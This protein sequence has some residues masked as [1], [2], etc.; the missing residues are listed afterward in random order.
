M[1]LKRNSKSKEINPSCV[2]TEAIA[3]DS[4]Q[5]NAVT[6]MYP[7][8]GFVTRIEHSLLYTMI[9]ESAIFPI[10]TV[11]QAIAEENYSV[12]FYVRPKKGQSVS[13]YKVSYA[14]LTATLALAA[15]EWPHDS[16]IPPALCQKMSQCVL[17]YA[18]DQDLDRKTE[19]DDL[20]QPLYQY[21]KKREVKQSKKMLKWIVPALGA[22]VL[23]GNPLPVYAAFLGANLAQTKE[24]EKGNISNINTNRMMSSGERLN[25]VEHTS[26]L[27]E[28]DDVSI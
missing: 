9:R 23:V 14:Q 20:L 26:L 15:E 5:V 13:E 8:S 12:Y 4:E 2:G 10:T 6:F 22:S 25:N 3:A 18:H 17:R 7:S 21:A 11:L 1:F 24:I 19:V 28:Y 16:E 27:E